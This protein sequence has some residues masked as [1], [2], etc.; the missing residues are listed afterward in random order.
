MLESRVAG[1]RLR[2]IVDKRVREHPGYDVCQLRQGGN[3]IVPV[4]WPPQARLRP[5]RVDQVAVMRKN[6]APKLAFCILIVVDP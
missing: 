2:V 1:Q 5:H 3:G 6:H 4:A